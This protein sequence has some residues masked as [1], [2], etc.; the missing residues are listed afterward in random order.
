MRIRFL[1]FVVLL[2]VTGPAAAQTPADTASV[3]LKVARDLERDGRPDAA[4]ELLR[5]LR[6][7]YGL[8][9]AARVADSLMRAMPGSGPIGNGRTGFVTFNT[10]YGAFLGA[11]IPAA[12]D[13]QGSGEY[14]LGLLLGAPAGFLLS[15]AFARAHFRSAG[16]AGIA[17]FA[18]A[19]GTWHGLALQQAADIGENETCNQFGCFTDESD[20]A[21]WAAMAL[22]GIAGI[23]VGWALGSAKQIRPGTA[24]MISHSA[25]W[26]SWFGLSVGTA[27]GVEGDGLWTSALA[28]GDAALLAAIPAAKAWQPTSSRVRLITAAGLAGALVGFGV[29][30]LADPNDERV[31]FAVPAATSALGLVI[32]TL[33][34]RNRDD[35]DI[36]AQGNDPARAL[37]EW[38][39]GLRLRFALPEPATFQKVDRNGK[40]R[41][42]PG[43]TLRIFDARF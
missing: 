10:L 35:L 14:G 38:K 42:V 23:G 7:K 30:L 40:S 29:D 15:R 4:R 24:T 8:T 32:G 1:A 19:W 37:L 18:T 41:L 36:A 28:A 33:A 11:A 31:V 5:Y 26:G 43:A 34:T 12:L 17:S 6:D 13:A 2:G 39:D 27:L 9:P 22:G 3:I 21:P 20:T 16:Q 25:L